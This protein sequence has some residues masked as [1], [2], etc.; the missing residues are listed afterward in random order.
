VPGLFAP[1]RMIWTVDRELA[2]LAGAGRA[3]LLQVAHPLVAAGVAG[4]SRFAERPLARLFRTLE[5]SYALVFGDLETARAASR[6]MDAVHRHVRGTLAERTGPFA[7]GTPYEAL[8]PGLQLWVH[9]TLVDTGLLVYDR[10]VARLSAAEAEAY[11]QDTR[12]L[13]AFI[14]IPPAIV[15]P[16][17]AAFRGYVS[18]MLRDELAVGATARE[19]ARLIFHPPRPA[20][21]V[22][23]GAVLR[24]V[25]SGLLPPRLRTGYGYRWGPGRERALG[26]AAAVSRR[27]LPCL[28]AVL[29]VAPP[30]RAAEARL[31]RGA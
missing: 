12:A 1:D 31:R 5:T 6:R 3:L 10:F 14:G 11:Y 29:R 30:A 21:M 27:A 23:V 9:A 4:H 2:L 18:A 17:L 16:T 25:T 20:L 8:D 7:A 22:P 26:L 15:P 13:A 28:P 24:T 19:L